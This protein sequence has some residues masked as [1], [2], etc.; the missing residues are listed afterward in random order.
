MFFKGLLSPLLGLSGTI[1]L[2][3]FGLPPRVS[4]DG[5]INLILE[6]QDEGEAKKYKLYKKFS[7]LGIALIGFSFLVQIINYFVLK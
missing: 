6:Q 2:F 4:K 5:T 7:Y 1:I 3:F